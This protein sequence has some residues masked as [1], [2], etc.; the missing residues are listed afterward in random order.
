MVHNCEKG[1]CDEQEAK[2]NDEQKSAEVEHPP[3][4]NCP[5][6][7]THPLVVT[8]FAAEKGSIGAVQS[9]P[10]RSVIGLTRGVANTEPVVTVHVAPLDW[11]LFH[12][13]VTLS[14]PSYSHHQIQLPFQ[15]HDLMCT[16]KSDHLALVHWPIWLKGSMRASIA[17]TDFFSLLALI[18][19][20]T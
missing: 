12:N 8:S 5:I 20:L 6:T 19:T 7:C 17:S 2:C 1:E 4:R 3:C 14:E 9:C 18:S 11:N 13:V 16:Q 10:T 15:E